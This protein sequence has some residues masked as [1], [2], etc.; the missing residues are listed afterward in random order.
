MKTINHRRNTAANVSGWVMLVTF[1]AATA[2]LNVWAA[3]L[4]NQNPWLHG[5]VPLIVLATALFAELVALSNADRF[6]KG[7]VVTLSMI[8]FGIVLGLSYIGVLRVL[9]AEYRPAEGSAEAV[10]VYGGAAVLDLLMIAA[11]VALVGLRIRTARSDAVVE[12]R[13]SVF[14][15]IGA[16]VGGLATS[17]L[18]KRREMIEAE[19]VGKVSE[20]VG[21]RFENTAPNVSNTPVEP[22]ENLFGE[23]RQDVSEPF[24]NPQ[25]TVPDTSAGV[26]PKPE[27]KVP[28]PAR[29]PQRKPPTPTIDPELEP[30]MDAARWMLKARRVSRKKPEEIAAWIKLTE[31]GLTPAQIRGRIGGGVETIENVAIAWREWQRR[32]AQSQPE[33]LSAAS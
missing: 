30:F 4:E 18:R 29:K 10:L 20:R 16:E 7:V 32:N 21:N 11:S 19:P 6:T 33:P 23:V 13:P 2:V 14:G 12:D 24:E 17:W 25:R 22:F 27:P 8:V 9:E 3:R 1:T 5:V 31:D 28:E 26:V 15:N